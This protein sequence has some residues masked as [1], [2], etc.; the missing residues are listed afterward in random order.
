MESLIN[1]YILYY[2]EEFKNKLEIIYGKINYEL[3]LS[4]NI[5]ICNNNLYMKSLN[6]NLI[7][8]NP[9]EYILN[10][11]EPEL[12]NLVIKANDYY[13]NSEPKISDEIYDIILDYIKDKYPKFKIFEEVG[14]NVSKNKIKLP[15]FMPSIEKIKPDTKSLEKWLVK[16]TSSKILSDKLDGMSLL[17]DSRNKPY[18][19][20]T[21]GNGEIGQDI[22]WILDYINMGSMNGG[23][24]RGELIISKNNWNII[25]SKNLINRYL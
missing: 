22:S 24:V 17:I 1:C 21:R 12:E 16:F 10:F 7:N 18:K 11:S 5:K 20:Y 15:V 13:Y 6:W 3:P 23:I 2:L 8:K 9:I 19:A 14:S 4:Y 25:K